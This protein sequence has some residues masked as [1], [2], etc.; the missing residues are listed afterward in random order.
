MPSAVDLA[1]RELVKLLKSLA[2]KY[3]LLLELSRDRS[4]NGVK[5]AVRKVSLKTHPDK[6]GDVADFQKLSMLPLES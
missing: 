3:K 5:K 2:S 1:K 6:G 4:D